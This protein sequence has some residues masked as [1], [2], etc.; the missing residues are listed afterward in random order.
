MKEL[1]RAAERGYADHGWL[2]SYHSF[3]FADYYDEQHMHF[4]PLRV[5]NEDWVAP[6]R[7]FGMH[8]H[9]DM[10]IVTYVLEGA[11]AHRD[12]MGNSSTISPGEVQRM[13]AGTG[14]M[15][16]EYNHASDQTTHL[17]QIWI[18]P[19]QRNVTPSYEQKTFGA[20]E[21][22][23]HLRLIV[24]PDG[25][26]GSVSIHQD[27]YVY[28]GLFNGDEQ[29]ERPLAEGRLAYIHIARGRVDVNGVVLQAGDALKLA[30]TAS[31]QVSHG[32]DAEILL[33]DLPSLNP[34]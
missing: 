22:R 12:S 17:L 25:R 10:E 20:T 28:A 27:A 6:G 18:M 31:V 30:S 32:R 1:R 24:S 16:S 13:S 7:G 19:N 11:L 14:V 5:I 15:H 26:N 3:S 2:Q 9:R 8:G 23:G 21:K 34:F 4:G 33:F 29:D